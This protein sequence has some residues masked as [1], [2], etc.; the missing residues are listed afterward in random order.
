MSL[1]ESSEIFQSINRKKRMAAPVL[2]GD[3][4]QQNPLEEVAPMAPEAMLSDGETPEEGLAALEAFEEPSE[5]K[6]DRHPLDFGKYQLPTLE[7]PVKEQKPA[8]AALPEENAPPPA[9]DIQQYEFPVFDQE[10][11]PLETEARP[12]AFAPADGAASE[13]QALLNRLSSA[14]DEQISSAFGDVP[15]GGPRVI[16]PLE[17]PPVP[18]PQPMPE[19]EPEPQPQPE[20]KGSSQ[21]L[22]AGLPV[23]PRRVHEADS[24]GERRLRAKRPIQ[25]K[26]PK[27]ANTPQPEPPP[28]EYTKVEEPAREASAGEDPMVDDFLRDFGLEVEKAVE[29]KTQSFKDALTEKYM[30]ERQRMLKEIDLDQNL[31]PSEEQASPPSP[32]RRLNV[33]VQPEMHMAQGEKAPVQPIGGYSRDFP[34]KP[35]FTITGPDVLSTLGKDREAP[36]APAKK[37]SE[38]LLLELGKN[39]GRRQAK[40]GGFVPVK[41][42]ANAKAAAVVTRKKSETPEDSPHR[43]WYMTMIP[44]LVVLMLLTLVLVPVGLWLAGRESGD[45]DSTVSVVEGEETLNAYETR[46]FPQQVAYNDVF[47]KKAGI[48]LKNM[49]VGNYLVIE[50][51]TSPGTIELE[52]VQVDGAIYIKDSAID[53]LSLRNVQ[54]ERVIITNP[55]SKVTLH[56]QG[57]SQVDTVEVKSP[58]NLLHDPVDMTGAGIRNVQV[59]AGEGA[60]NLILTNL[61]AE[62]VAISGDAV[63]QL[64]NSEIASMSGEGNVS[65]SGKGKILRLD[66]GSSAEATKLVVHIG[67]PR[68]ENLTLRGPAELTVTGDIG[69]LIAASSLSVSGGGTVDSLTVNP[70]TAGNRVLVDLAGVNV[71]NLTAN[72]P[73]R[74]FTGSG[75]R[76]NNVTANE[77]TYLLGTKVNNLMVNAPQVIYE[78]QPDR[79]TVKDGVRP[80]ETTADNPNLDYSLNQTG[81]LVDVTGDSVATTCGHTRE[82]G[83]FTRGDGSKETPFEVSTPAQLAHISKHLTS[84]FIQTADLNLAEDSAFA[85]SFPVIAGEGAPFSG[86]YNGNGYRIRNLKITTATQHVGLFGQNTGLIQGITIL[87]G[88]IKA[89]GTGASVGAVAGMNYSGGTIASCSNGARVS[90]VAGSYIGGL[91]GYNFGGKIGDSYNTAQ[92]T[93]ADIDIGG[94]AGV[95]RDGGSIVSGYNVGQVTG[96]DAGA[97]A[98]T[99]DGSVITNC[100][101]QEGTAALAIGSGE[102]SASFRTDEEMRNALLVAE[103]SVGRSDAPWRAG[104]GSYEFPILSVPHKTTGEQAGSAAVGG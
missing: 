28:L 7:K 85:S 8:A 49:R 19:P 84:H 83:G 94:L 43:P 103:L 51:I 15:K 102:G 20:R 45:Q 56:L 3:A 89:T 104:S 69:G 21:E 12:S 96:T 79:I 90:G 38:E 16:Q 46:I 26:A 48:L 14:F 44:V 27:A 91:V 57:Q 80:P 47:I 64:E 29:A 60:A 98:G 32:P 88:E 2:L 63:I 70:D 35:M 37:T 78:T 1:K 76:V 74:L 81:G 31:T 5:E 10:P 68:V 99:N 87:S 72:G 66:T 55:Q 33:E 61:S 82:E 18:Q 17:R 40:K 9:V 39:G 30:R 34:N 54:A 95:N 25:E 101:A 24:G 92:V 71:H 11:E 41:S 4:A 75:A 50:N 62:T 52:D 36:P 13:Y 97:I 23:Q 22:S 67:G 59:K 42:D 100:Y 73:T 77:S 93:G 58:V 6:E 65:L 86:S 53:T